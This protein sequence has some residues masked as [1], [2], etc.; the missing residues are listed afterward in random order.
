MSKDKIR[1]LIR[2]AG[3][4]TTFEQD[5]LYRLV[6]LTVKECAR[7]A[8]QAEPYQTSDLIYKHFGME[9]ETHS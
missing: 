8:D 5:R 6:C 4:S 1:N 2:E 9:D 7:I 3:F